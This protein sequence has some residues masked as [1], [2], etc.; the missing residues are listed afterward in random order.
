MNKQIEEIQT[1]EQHALDLSAKRD[2]DTKFDAT[3][4][5]EESASLHAEISGL[6]AKL[7]AVH[8]R[9]KSEK[10]TF[11]ACSGAERSI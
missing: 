6:T 1:L 7:S 8:E 3:K 11:K 5:A 10:E 2:T 9:M 4:H